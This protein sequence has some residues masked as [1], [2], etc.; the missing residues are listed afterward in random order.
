MYHANNGRKTAV[1]PSRE[2][3]RAVNQNGSN[4]ADQEAWQLSFEQ[5]VIHAFSKAHPLLIF[6]QAELSTKTFTSF[7]PTSLSFRF[8]NA[9]CYFFFLHIPP[10]LAPPILNMTSTKRT[11]DEMSGADNSDGRTSPRAYRRL[12]GFIDEDYSSEENTPDT[13]LSSPTVARSSQS[14]QQI[15]MNIPL[16][17]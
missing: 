9:H 8:L 5:A 7:L 17:N 16:P 13:Y 11:A 10:K 2:R 3:E 4:I 6:T 14:S 15:F 1:R 12:E